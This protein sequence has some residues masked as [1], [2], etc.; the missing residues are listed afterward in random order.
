MYTR[1]SLGKILVAVFF[2]GGYLDTLAH[3]RNQTSV[4]IAYFHQTVGS[5]DSDPK[6]W[7]F[8][9]LLLKYCFTVTFFL[10]LIKE[11]KEG[12]NLFIK[13]LGETVSD[14]LTCFRFVFN[15]N[16]VKAVRNSIHAS[17]TKLTVYV[18]IVHVVT[19]I[20]VVMNWVLMS[21][22]VKEITFIIT[23]IWSRASFIWHAA[24]CTK[25]FMFT[26]AADLLSVLSF[27][28]VKLWR[29]LVWGNRN[30]VETK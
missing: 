19:A 22:T 2:L 29:R 25:V 30:Y 11:V 4:D 6:L 23:L 16:C 21:F 10:R 27:K 12:S 13:S 28:C 9:F 18:E 26:E 17:I 8:T 1:I 15:W 5:V 7:L 14:F 20:K 24:D 3:R